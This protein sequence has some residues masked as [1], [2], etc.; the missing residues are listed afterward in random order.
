MKSNWPFLPFI[1]GNDHLTWS[2]L[3]VID[4]ISSRALAEELFEIAYNVAQ[5]V[6]TRI[7][8]SLLNTEIGSFRRGVLHV[9]FALP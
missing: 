1:G 8:H 4:A 3:F 2:V 7:Y 5:I 6:E 9:A